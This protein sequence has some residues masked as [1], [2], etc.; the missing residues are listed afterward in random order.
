M[1]GLAAALL[2]RSDA[3]PGSLLLKRTLEV[4]GLNEP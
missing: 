4:Y 2:T 1:C 3:V